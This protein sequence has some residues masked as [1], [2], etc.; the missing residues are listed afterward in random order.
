MLDEYGQFVAA[1]FPP[2]LLKPFWESLYVSDIRKC[3]KKEINEP[4]NECFVYFNLY[5]Y[6]NCTSDA[7]LSIY[8]KVKYTKCNILSLSQ[9]RTGKKGRSGKT[10]KRQIKA[11]KLTTQRPEAV[12]KIKREKIGKTIRRPNEG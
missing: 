4:M 5:L 2:C 8:A 12:K 10:K 6:K 7:V 9:M 11:N 3:N 1:P